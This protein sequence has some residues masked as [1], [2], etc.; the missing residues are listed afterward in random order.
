MLDGV[1]L[2]DG[3]TEGLAVL[4]VLDCQLEGRLANAQGL[5]GDTDAPG[6]QRLH[7]DREALARLAQQHVL[8]DLCTIGG[9]GARCEGRGIW[10]DRSDGPRYC[11]D[12][13]AHKTPIYVYTQMHAYLDVLEDEVGGGR[14]ADAELVLL[15]AQGEARRVA[16]HDEGADA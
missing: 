12:C 6:V 3:G 15:L 1:E 7:G 2:G 13:D 11:E 9:G 4:G 8:G 5:C 14:G 10:R 16:R